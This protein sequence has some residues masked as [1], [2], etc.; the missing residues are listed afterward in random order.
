MTLHFRRLALPLITLFVLAACKGDPEPTDDTG[1]S[2]CEDDCWNN[3]FAPCNAGCP[4][5]C[6]GMTGDE[7]DRCI[8]GCQGDC[9]VPYEECVTNTCSD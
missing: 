9:L 5:A 8:D 3:Q 4:D 1:R 2:A 7:Y 6:Q